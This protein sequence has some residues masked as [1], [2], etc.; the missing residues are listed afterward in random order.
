PGVGEPIFVSR[1]YNSISNRVGLFGQGWTTAYDEK[2]ATNQNQLELTMPDGRL[3]SFATPDFFGQIV[4]N[5]DGSYTVTFK[6]GRVHQ[7]NAAGR[8]VSQSDRNGNQTTL[9]YDAIGRL[10]SVTDAFGRV[11]TVTTDSSGKVLS[12]SDAS[13]TIAT[14]TYSVSEEL[15][16]VTYADNS[17]YQFTYVPV[18]NNAV[19]TSVRDALGNVI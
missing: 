9:G 4:T 17:G 19:L 8:L 10:A 16:T 13:G 5:A 7:F 6:D 14:Y 2:V 15:L 3:I 12:I 11:L 18:P 1:S